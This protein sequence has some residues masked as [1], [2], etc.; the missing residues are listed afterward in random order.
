LG[1]ALALDGGVIYLYLSLNDWNND[2]YQSLQQL[3]KAAF[4]RCVGIYTLF[5][6]S[7]SLCQSFHT[8]LCRSLQWQW[9]SWL[10]QVYLPQWLAHKGGGKSSSLKGDWDNPDQ[11]FT[12]D[13]KNF[14]EV[15]IRL[16]L[17]FLREGL[18]GILFM[19]VLWQL[20]GTAVLSL[21][22]GGKLI[23]HGYIL[24]FILMYAIVT[25]G[26]SAR[27]GNPLVRLGY[28]QESQEASF[29]SGLL[30]YLTHPREVAGQ[31]LNFESFVSRCLGV[32]G[33]L[34]SQKIRWQ[35][36]LQLWGD[37][38]QKLMYLFPILVG[39]PQYFA[40]VLTFGGLMQLRNACATVQG[41]LLVIVE[42]YDE[43]AAWR[44]TA[45]R[46][47][48][49]MADLRGKP[50]KKA[51][52]ENPPALAS[53]LSLDHV[54]FQTPD[55][56]VLLEGVNLK[57]SPG[58]SVLIYGPSGSGKTSLLQGIIG[59]GPFLKGRILGPRPIY[60]VPQHLYI[61]QG[62]LEL[63]LTPFGGES[64][65]KEQET[66]LSLLGLESFI[67]SPSSQRDWR[68]A[69]S[70]SEGGRLMIARALLSRPQVLLIDQ[71]MSV[72]DPEM[73][74]TLLK[75]I[76]RFLPRVILLATASRPPFPKCSYTQS[77]SLVPW[78]PSEKKVHIK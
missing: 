39:A 71:V 49:L 5:I 40:G 19:G 47:G 43:I 74:A 17:R 24:W 7:L 55:Q 62:A 70:A 21:P 29:R 28:Q 26:V 33:D 60:L 4:G 35:M 9:R 8:Y 50:Q 6:F 77:M 25:T 3:D 76:Q 78:M 38:V 31:H 51:G 16:G 64:Q 69:L 54:S 34:F 13:I 42:S 2:F 67:S 15:S 61:P 46:L 75:R 68:N 32:V 14:T 41:S 11:R 73:E 66:V 58:E 18:N 37:G 44:A 20:S 63:F 72:L 65:K 53:S 12:E 10:T 30:G 1:S 57:V 48:E 22:W 27:I 56:K 52:R 59:G 45:Q 36:I 23:I